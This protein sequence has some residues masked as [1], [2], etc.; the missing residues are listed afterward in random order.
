MSIFESALESCQLV[1]TKIVISLFYLVSKR[2]PMKAYNILQY[3]NTHPETADMKIDMYRRL[4]SSVALLDPKTAR[5]SQL[6]AF[7]ETLLT[8]LDSMEEEEKQEVY[9]TLVASLVSQRSVGIGPF[10]GIIYNYMIINEFDMASGWLNKLLSASKYNRQEDLPFD[11][12]LARLVSKGE[13][14]HP[15]STLPVIHNMFPYTNSSQMSV[16]LQALLDIYSKCQEEGNEANAALYQEYSI[17]LATLEMIS[18]GAAKAGDPELILL[19]WEVLEM[20]GFKPTEQIYENTVVAFACTKDGLFQAFAALATMKDEGFEVSRAVIRSFSRAIRSKRRHVDNAF[21]LLTTEDSEDLQCLEN[22]N[23]VMSSYAERGDVNETLGILDIISQHGLTP[24]QDSYSFAMEVLGKDLHRRKSTK[25][26]AWVHKNIELASTLLTMME[27]ECIA[28]SADVVRNYVE[29]LCMG[30]ELGTATALIE[31]CLSTDKMTSIINNK[32]LYRV[33]LSNAEAGNIDKAKELAARTS[34]TIPV[35][36][37]KIRS[38]E[39]RFD[40]LESMRKIRERDSWS[41]AIDKD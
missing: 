1:D 38:K 32:T 33:A 17:D 21:R 6:R 11:D 41:L 12:V 25:D 31:D 20:T 35:L 29:L 4:C 22:F 30:N 2:H 13:I 28:P 19:V 7:I 16:V 24:N 10:A 9:P 15:L 40:H 3:Y 27:K 39:Q 5:H 34:E 23:V 37:R 18:A 8:E 26:K 36:H 14:P